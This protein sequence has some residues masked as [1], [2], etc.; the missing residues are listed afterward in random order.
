ML[1]QI[2]TDPQG[3]YV[4]VVFTIWG[5]GYVVVNVYVPPPF[6]LSIL[7]TVLERITPYCHARLLLMGNFNAILAP[8]MD[9]PDP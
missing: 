9:R 8:D 1:K 3:K 5:T 6:S 4:I 2:N 7:Y